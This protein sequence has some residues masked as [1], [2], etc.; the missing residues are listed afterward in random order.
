MCYKKFL[1]FFLMYS[2]SIFEGEFLGEGKVFMKVVIFGGGG[3]L[4]LLLQV[5]M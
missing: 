4:S 5:V 3:G 2:F 1:L